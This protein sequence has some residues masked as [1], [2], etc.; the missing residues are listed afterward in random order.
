MYEKY[1]TAT[2]TT[3]TVLL[4]LLHIPPLVNL[5]PAKKQQSMGQYCR[6]KSERLHANRN[7]GSIP[8]TCYFW[9]VGLWRSRIWLSYVNELMSCWDVWF[10][11]NQPCTHWVPG[12]G[13]VVPP[14][15]YYIKNLKIW[16]ACIKCAHVHLYCLCTHG[17]HITYP[18]CTHECTY[19]Y[20]MYVCTCT[21]HVLRDEP[22]DWTL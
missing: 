14:A 11:Q 9:V 4:L 8:S 7:Q 1:F 16:N 19:M 10:Q 2:C 20:V 5:D 15:G 22:R 18:A 13:L 3:T 21:H 17:E 12:P 6:V